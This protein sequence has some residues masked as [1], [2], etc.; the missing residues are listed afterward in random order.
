MEHT[1]FPG[2]YVL[3]NKIR[4]GTKVPKRLQDIPVVGDIFNTKNTKHEYDLYR[5]LKGFKT[6]QREDIVVFK[7]VEDNNRFLIKR[8][9]GLPGDTLNIKNT[10]VVIN[11]M[12]LPER[13]EYSYQYRDS[14]TS[15]VLSKIYANK[16]FDT[17]DF[18]RKKKLS[19]LNQT[20]PSLRT[21]NIFPFTKQEQWTRDN[22][23]PIII[24]KKG[25]HIIFTKENIAIYKALIAN[26]EQEIIQLN[27]DNDSINYT[28]KHN[29]YF[30][31]GDNRHNS[32]DSR[33]YGFVP[34]VY[35]QG[36]MILK[37]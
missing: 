24:P 8:L 31:L 15:F 16:V 33:S 25:M 9:I 17:L 28:F 30:M 5:A 12:S 3:V 1:L 10:H 23:G 29:Y 37:F 14:S 20:K 6:L 35:I 7:S 36:K 13:S 34:E 18:K 32:I 21:Y 27:D 11:N 19:K 26:Y 22:Y 4:Y 2:D